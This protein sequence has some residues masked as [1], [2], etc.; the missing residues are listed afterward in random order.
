MAEDTTIEQ[1]LAAVE[2]ELRKLKR[3][4]ESADSWYDR[5]T[6]AFEND[7]AFEELLDL[8]RQFRESQGR[9]DEGV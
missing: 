2:N 3:K 8:G 4:I 7:P 9:A 5:M 6:G 1:R